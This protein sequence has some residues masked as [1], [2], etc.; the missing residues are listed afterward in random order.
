MANPR[1]LLL[2][3]HGKIALFLT[4]L[5][6]DRSW[7]VT[8]AI[9]NPEQTRDILKLGK[10]KKGRVEVSVSSL[11]D[12]KSADDA[13]AIIERV[14]PN[15]IVWAAG[16]GGKGD[17]LRT[18]TIDR[19]AAKHF[20]TAAFND[21]AITKFLLISHIGSR[22]KQPSWLSAETWKHF[23]HINQDVLP[24][25][26]QAKLA[27]DEYFTVMA[28][29]RAEMDDQLGRK[30]DQ[31]FQAIL[32]RP[33]ALMDAPATWKV[34]LGKTKEVY[35]EGGVAANVSRED[36][37]IVADRLLARGDTR[38][39]LDLLGGDD[40][41]DEAVEMVVRDRVDAVDGEDFNM[42]CEAIKL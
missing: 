30:G 17:P 19:D 26:Y 1:V 25:Y 6:L 11:D 42:M 21:P 7:D 9:R 23:E 36:V 2:G 24:D 38:G 10:G 32:L 4:P 31:R 27:A 20:I 5:L 40:D 28:R 8:S 29:K 39:W 12:V 14:K 16:A 3:G 35:L 41:V 33:G 34:E 18:Y 37:A 13:K 15:Y 22:R